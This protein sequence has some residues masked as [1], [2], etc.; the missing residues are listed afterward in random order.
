MKLITTCILYL[1]LLLPLPAQYVY[2]TASPNSTPLNNLVWRVNTATCEI[3]PVLNYPIASPTELLILPN[4]DL[5]VATL[6]SGI[7]RFDPPN[8]N[9]VA[10][11][12]GTFIGAQVHPNGT[13]YISNGNTLSTFN[14]AT[15]TFTLVGSFPPNYSVYELFFYNGQ[16]YGIA[17][18][19]I[20]GSGSG[21][22]QINLANPGASTIVQI[23]PQNYI[24]ATSA[25]N[26]TI[27][28]GD[29]NS[30]IYILT[31]NYA[32][33]TDTPG[34]LIP[35]ELAYVQNLTT[36][37][38]GVPELP[39]VCLGVAA[40][41]VQNTLN[42]CVPNNA[43]VLF[44]NN[45]LPDF[46]D[47]VRYILYTNPAAPLSSIIQT[48]TTPEF[49]YTPPVQPG[50]TYYVAQIV[51]DELNGN[52]NLQ[53]PCLQISTAVAVT[54]RP[55][56]SLTALTVQN[57]NLCPGTCSTVSITLNGTPPFAY[58]WEVQQ[59]GSVLTPLNVVFNINS[60]TSTFQACVPAS[61]MGGG[62]TVAICGITD[63]YCSNP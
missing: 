28:V 37:P 39:C 21:L 30:P 10:T 15:N 19:G 36:V 31:Y 12:P 8:N 29:P 13:I 48:N 33:N 59:N 5:L 61:A 53:D 24:A 34:C 4:G 43:T 62:A 55:K 41:P 50:V 27:Y 23:P 51:G 35:A 7:L 25:S 63:A 54:W 14:P 58:S 17:D 1:G 52:V 46:N 56:P 49:T 2:F 20:P 40:T 42:A 6:S 32:T 38:A 26:G 57:N 9:P 16:L 47:L 44:N 60:N 3:C 45:Q 11:I 22:I 18:N